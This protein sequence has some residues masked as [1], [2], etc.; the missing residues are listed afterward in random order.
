M[1]FALIAPL[2]LALIM[3]V[4]EYGDRFRNTATY[5]NAALVAARSYSISDTAGT[6]T[7]A[8]RNA[9]IPASVTPTYSFTFDDGS[10]ASSCMPAS[11][12]TY[13]NVTVTISRTG[14]PAV[15]PL[16]QL[17]PGIASTFTITGKAVAR[18]AA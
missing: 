15:T 2:L 1:E 6:A 18:C 12:G 4:I 7:S 13:P 11:D 10:P 5:D 3:G 8:A 16:P 9:G 17:L 14:V